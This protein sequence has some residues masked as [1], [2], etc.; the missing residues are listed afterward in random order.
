MADADEQA[1][2]VEEEEKGA[3]EE[4]KKSKKQKVGHAWRAMAH[5][6]MQQHAHATHGAV[7]ALLSS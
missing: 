4:Q 6:G 3:E 1:P 2:T 5:A 7:L